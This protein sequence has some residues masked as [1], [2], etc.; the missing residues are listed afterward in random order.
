LHLH[1]V[2][3][4]QEECEAAEAG[5][6]TLDASPQLPYSDDVMNVQPL[7]PLA[8]TL[9]AFLALW[10][11]GLILEK[12]IEQR[13]HESLRIFR[14]LVLPCIIAAILLK[15]NFGYNQTSIAMKAAATALGFATVWFLA[16]VLKAL[17]F[18]KN[19]SD[20]LTGRTPRLLVDILRLVF[21]IVGFLLVY[22]GIWQKDISPLLTTFGVG[23]L[24]LGLALQDTLGNLFAGLSLVFERPIAVGDWIQVG[25]QVGRVQ[26]INWR[27]TRIVT[28]ELT[29]ITIPNSAIGKE[30]L[31]NFSSPTRVHGFKVSCGFSYDAPPNTVKE[32]LFTAAI[33]T[34]GV[35]QSPAPEARTFEFGAYAIQYEL[36]VFIA[37]YDEIVSVRNELMSRIWYHAKRRGIS[38]PFPIT[39]L[40]KTEVPFAP[41]Q[42]AQQGTIQ[43][44]IKGAALFQDLSAGDIT[45]L[46]EES[47]LERFASG[48][49]LIKEGDIGD[50]FYIIVEGRCSVMV[51]SKDGR[52]VPVA[53]LEKGSVVGEMSLLSGNPRQASVFASSDLVLVRIS[54]DA[55]GHLL[56][57]HPAIL[58]SFAHYAAERSSQ[59]GVALDRASPIDS[60]AQTKP[61]ENALRERLRRFF[62]LSAATT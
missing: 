37:D 20:S 2:P 36:R 24:V 62:G 8:A 34:P 35:L 17:V 6:I 46:A 1:L 26:Q 59:I 27:S 50:C 54:K 10:A 31:H 5:E 41:Q 48:E 9:A 51:N 38:I 33:E 4:S 53:T 12:R 47:S 29:E 18:L 44:A 56:S 45:A 16:S 7:I 3:F 39:T 15:E 23:S 61:D 40:Y 58:Q 52:L 28:R 32:M 21:V 25:D 42:D 57:R 30:R 13:F 22:S 43:A 11:I 19:S 60:P 55:L 49:R 14:T